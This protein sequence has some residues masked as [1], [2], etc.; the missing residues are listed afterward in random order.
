MHL[1]AVVD[2][3]SCD[4]ASPIPVVQSLQG[5]LLPCCHVL[6][7]VAL[8]PR[9]FPHLQSLDVSH[10]QVQEPLPEV[11]V[12]WHLCKRWS[13]LKEVEFG[14]K[15]KLSL[16]IFDLQTKRNI[17]KDSIKIC[18]FYLHNWY[19]M[20]TVR[21]WGATDGKSYLITSQMYK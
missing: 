9:L 11:L 6:Q 2:T 1:D 5:L 13:C 17:R 18:Y 4:N 3:G 16:L 15:I 12:C 10:S 14:T 8:A 20:P 7:A 21:T 19:I